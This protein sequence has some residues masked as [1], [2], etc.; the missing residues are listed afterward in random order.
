MVENLLRQLI[1]CPSVTPND[2][3][4]QDIVAER[5]TAAGFAVERMRF[6]EVE[7]LWA[8][9][10]SGKPVVCLA[11][12]TD[13]VPPGPLDAWSSDPFVAEERDGRLY[14]RGAADM[15][16]SVAAMTLA[17]ESV[18]A[19]G[20]A[21]TIALLLTSDEEGPGVDGTRRVLQTLIERGTIIDAAIVGEPT[22]EE[23]FGDTV[24]VGRRGSM[25]GRL[26]VRGVQGHTAYPQLADNAVH[27]LAPALAALV[28]ADWGRGTSDFPA[29][30]L[31]VSNLK[32]GTGAGNVI[33]GQ[34]E[35]LFNFRFGPD[36]SA[37]A[38][39]ARVFEILKS[40]DLEAELSWSISALPFLTEPGPLLSALTAAIQEVTGE[41][42]KP[43][44]GGGTS[45][46]RFF[47]A[48]GIPVA[49]FGP[50]NASIHAA[51]E[52][53][54]LAPLEPLTRIYERVLTSLM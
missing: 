10:G 49:E 29:T 18:A 48:H 21:G 11:G 37:E 4:C 54:E 9:H 14:G 25:G 1:A 17:L 32:A 6:G 47:A 26:V 5:L 42:P 41:T 19:G 2:A 33:P 38:L 30:T 46:A 15:K 13:V 45:D 22:S 28:S 44:T 16:A 34:A 51:N 20:H 40:A 43:S 24:K 53:V 27:K 39:Q 31:Q 7:N 35:A 36:W 50:L 12:H 8:T 52:W 23:T 3:G